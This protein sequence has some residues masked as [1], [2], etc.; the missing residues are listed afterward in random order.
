[1][2]NWDSS[3]TD[4]PLPPMEEEDLLPAAPKRPQEPPLPPRQPKPVKGRK[5]G[6]LL[7]R[8]SVRTYQPDKEST[9]EFDALAD[10]LAGKLG[11][12]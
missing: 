12:S 3:N 10:G 2:P 11:Y 1:M 7:P 4:Y 6:G 9:A 5:G 8:A